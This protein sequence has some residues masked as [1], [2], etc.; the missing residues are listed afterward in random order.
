M[1]ESKDF[2]AEAGTAKVSGT[3]SSTDIA[4]PVAPP[5]GLRAIGPRITFHFVGEWDVNTSYVLYD[6]VRVNGTSYIANKITI[7]KGVN[8][9]T[10]N[11]VHWVRWNDPNAQV[12]LLQ[13]T[14]NGFD[15]R[16]TAAQG[17]ADAA[18]GVADAAKGAADAAQGAADAAQATA[19]AA[20]NRAN[21]SVIYC[22]NVSDIATLNVALGDVIITKGFHTAGDGGS[23]EYVVTNSSEADEM[24]TFNCGDYSATLNITFPNAL[25][26]GFKQNAADFDNSLLFPKY[27]AH[28]R[29]NLYFPAGKYYFKSSTPSMRINI[30]GA[31]R[32][33][34]ATDSIDGTT[35][36]Y[37][38]E[39][40]FLNLK[41]QSCVKNITFIGDSYDLKFDRSKCAKNVDVSTET[42]IKQVTCIKIADPAYGTTITGCV[43]EHFYNAVIAATFCII[44]GNNINESHQG[45]SVVSDCTVTNN[46]FVNTYTGVFIN[47]NNNIIDNTRGDSIGKYLIHCIGSENIIT[48]VNADYC[49][50]NA[51]YLFNASRNT[52]KNVEARCGTIYPYD[53]TTDGNQE[54]WLPLEKYKDIA[55]VGCGGYVCA[56]NY[57]EVS[58]Y[59]RNP[60]DIKSNLK[61]S[62]F[63][64]GVEHACFNVSLNALRSQNR[65]NTPAKTVLYSGID[66][67]NNNSISLDYCRVGNTVGYTEGPVSDISNVYVVKGAK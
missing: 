28:T 3:V 22:D 47:G 15:G 54:A 17:V 50:Y 26:L 66:I 7:A 4:E 59:P 51:I 8:P 12:E 61:C 34:T 9:E 45:L 42:A 20:Q 60:L 24:F 46:R 49:Q 63:A 40:S 16:I 56:H 43:I 64:L 41:E 62:F 14:V 32:S 38:G 44:D 55:M 1:A 13:Q 35:F 11:N 5:M 19:D 25:Q 48:N 2:S 31:S 18:K 6:V 29:T 58:N 65:G 67:G 57:I 33:I 27:L 21:K 37:K 10:D 36:Y 23:A 30:E 52:I 39:N 53:S